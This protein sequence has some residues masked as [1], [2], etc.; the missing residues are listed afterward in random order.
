MLI[1]TAS[2]YFRAFFGVPASLRSP[3]GQPVNA[4]RGLLD[5]IARLVSQYP[6]DRFACCWDDDWRPAWRVELLP[7]Y[8]AHRVTDGD[9]DQVPDDLAVQVPVIREVLETL[10][11]P[12]LGM[13][14]MEAD[15]VIASLAAQAPGPVIVVTGDRDLFQLVS[16]SRGVEVLYVARGVSKHERVTDDWL[17]ERYGITGAQYVD[18][19][20]LRG[21]PSDGLP[22]VRGIGEKTASTL[23]SRYGDLAGIRDHASELTPRTRQALES[24]SDYVARAERVVRVVADLP[25]PDHDLSLPSGPPDPGAFDLLAARIGLGGSATRILAALAHSTGDKT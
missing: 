15:D 14:G 3:D 18:F 25:L 6:V 24:A 10:G 16:D 23:V 22:G 19:A 5:A 2:L 13:L 12:V 20:V 7:S 1:D 8:K 17:Q 21:D 4:V 11:L 9:A